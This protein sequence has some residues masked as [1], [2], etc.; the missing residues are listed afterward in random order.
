V[1]FA[2]VL[3]HDVFPLAALLEQLTKMGEEA[4]GRPVEIEFAARLPQ[5]TGEPAD[6]GF[7]QVRPLVLSREGEELR[8]EEVDPASLVCQSSKVLGN[9]RVTD[10]R[11]VVVVDFH[12]FERA[13][14]KEVACGV[15]HFN[16][17]LNAE[18]RPYLLIGVG[19]WGSTEPW[20][21]IPVEWDEI[22]GARVIVEAGFRDFR[23]TPS[24]GSHFFQNLTAFQ[25]GYFTV[26]P[27][28]G[29]GFVDWQWLNETASVEEDGCV[30][31]LR[32]EAPLNVV[33]NGR[34]S[35]GLIFK[36]EMP[37]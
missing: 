25:V 14:S 23:V 3:K 13:R 6:F 2:P 27:D 4:F 30:R 37:T 26:N 19:R 33:M 29:E 17:K 36:P 1:S 8:L 7:L 22:S 20:L 5:K 31:H 15:A 35:Q 34:T 10:L 18:G 28:A 32:F 11:D 24:Q 9:G 21:G 16:A 12:R